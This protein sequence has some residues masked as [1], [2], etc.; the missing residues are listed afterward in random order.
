MPFI[1]KRM[2]NDNSKH[3]SEEQAIVKA[4]VDIW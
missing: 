3:S 2:A 4:G 1:I